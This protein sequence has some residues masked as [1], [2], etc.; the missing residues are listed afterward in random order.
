[1]SGWRSHLPQRPAR[2]QGS[3]VKAVGRHGDAGTTRVAAELTGLRRVDWVRLVLDVDAPRAEVMGVG[4]RLPVCQQVPISTAS[5]L[6][7]A[8]LPY[9]LC[10][11][12][13]ASQHHGRLSL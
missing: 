13:P 2:G 1:M 10:R 5:R 9:V 11:P 7:A 8:G 12:Q 4:H 6:V 3:P